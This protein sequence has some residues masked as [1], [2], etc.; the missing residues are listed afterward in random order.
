ME[1]ESQT[2]LDFS[3]FLAS[4]QKSIVYLLG[5]FLCSCILRQDF[6][7]SASQKTTKYF[8]FPRTVM[9]YTVRRSLFLF[10]TLICSGL[11]CKIFLSEAISIL[12]SKRTTDHRAIIIWNLQITNY[13]H[14]SNR[15]FS[16]K[17]VLRCVYD[18]SLKS[19]STFCEKRP[20]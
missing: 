4:H 18:L 5:T 11:L 8:H 12:M 1:W 10:T 17:K 14:N 6:N 13:L 3:Y 9:Y 15:P 16:W 7:E 20:A 2:N 19:S